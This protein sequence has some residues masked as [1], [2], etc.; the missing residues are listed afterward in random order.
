M[1]DPERRRIFQDLV[2]DYNERF[3]VCERLFTQAQ[4]A[5]GVG[6]RNQARELIEERQRI[7][8]EVLK[9]LEPYM[10][11]KPGFLV[12][13]AVAAMARDR[14]GATINEAKG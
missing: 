11:H 14:A 6:N 9:E 10:A 7:W 3:R 1:V 5:A 8:L 4:V 2:D 13:E 12:L